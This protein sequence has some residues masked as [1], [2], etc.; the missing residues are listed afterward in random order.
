MGDKCLYKVIKER[1]PPY[2]RSTSV[3]YGWK[4][5]GWPGVVIEDEAVLSTGGTAIGVGS[6]DVEGGVSP[7]L[8]YACANR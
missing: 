2:A 4:R 6:D 7:L 3:L 1:G 8:P 5:D